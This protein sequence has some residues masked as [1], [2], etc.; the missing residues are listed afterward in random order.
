MFF[1]FWIIIM[2][3]FSSFYSSSLSSFSFFFLFSIFF[4]I[5]FFFLLLFFLSLLLS[6][7]S[8]SFRFCSSYPYSCSF[9]FS[10]FS[11]CSSCALLL[12]LVLL[13]PLVLSLVLL[14]LLQL[15][16]FFFL[17][18]IAALFLVLLSFCP[19]SCCF[20]LQFLFFFSSLLLSLTL[21]FSMFSYLCSMSSITSLFLWPYQ[22]ATTI[23]KDMLNQ[24]VFFEQGH[25]HWTTTSIQW[26]LTS[27]YSAELC[28]FS[29][30][31]KMVKSVAQWT[32]AVNLVS[33]TN[34]FI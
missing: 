12:F 5:I 29:R 26:N 32:A 23:T 25:R 8:C 11:S 16:F 1:C 33:Q 14:V 3:A 21:S 13:V 18:L 27:S 20:V 31:I 34:I 7:F 4:N 30:L 28:C 10:C 24:S 17:L 9:C 19:S 2:N 15:F 22:H 6:Y